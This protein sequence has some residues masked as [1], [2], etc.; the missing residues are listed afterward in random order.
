MQVQVFSREW[1]RYHQV[2]L[3]RFANTF[4]GKMVFGLDRKDQVI[5]ITPRTVTTLVG[6]DVKNRVIKCQNK[7][8]LENLYASRLR[9]RLSPVWATM[10]L[11]DWLALDRQQLIPDFGFA[12]YGPADQ[13]DEGDKY[14]GWIRS[15]GPNLSWSTLR[16]GNNLA[17]DK[18][19]APTYCTLSND[20]AANCYDLMYRGFMIWDHSSI[21]SGATVTNV[22]FS[23]KAYTLNP[24]DVWD[25][26]SNQ[27]VVLT[28]FN[29]S[30]PE[31][32][33]ANDWSNFIGTQIYTK[34]YDWNGSAYIPTPTTA[35]YYDHT[36]ANNSIT[37][38]G[39]SSWGLM[40]RGDFDNVTPLGSGNDDNTDLNLYGNID[41]YALL[42]VT[43]ISG[44]VK[45]NIGDVWK[46]IES[47]QI[48]IGDSWKTLAELK[49]NIG[50]VWK[51]III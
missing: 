15:T 35:S 24:E 19:N 41:D 7:G 5:A 13:Y 28:K 9:Q 10:H 46:D 18:T 23:V 29:P 25:I 34:L 4:F 27:D 6:I 47:I 11:I 40:L 12:T 37:V 30:D 3:V 50:D 21:V 39:T 17:I 31:N 38:N 16:T 43:Y 45:V 36:I 32:L 49:I 51:D 20:A 33:V 14:H 26:N 22:N 42:T 48:N 44:H 2:K 1:F 8:Y